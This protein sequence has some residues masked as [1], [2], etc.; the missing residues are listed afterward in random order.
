MSGSGV[1]SR[2]G[3]KDGGASESVSQWDGQAGRQPLLLHPTPPHH[4]ARQTHSQTPIFCAVTEKWSNILGSCPSV[5]MHAGMVIWSVKSSY[6]DW[7]P[8]SGSLARIS[9]KMAW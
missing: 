1:V 4:R 3:G 6:M 9:L 2:G 5:I 7:R 8:P